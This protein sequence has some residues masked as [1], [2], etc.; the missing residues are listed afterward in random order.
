MRDEIP[1]MEYCTVKP[2]C[3]KGVTPPSNGSNCNPT[4]YSQLQFEE[5]PRIVAAKQESQVFVVYV[6]FDATRWTEIRCLYPSIHHVLSRNLTISR[7]VLEQLNTPALASTAY[8]N[9]ELGN[10]CIRIPFIMFRHSVRRFATTACKAAE[11]AAQMEARNAYGV[12]VSK[13]QGV[14]NGLT[15]CK[16]YSI[17]SSSL[18]A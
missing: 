15:E 5:F 7:E 16:L 17:S 9:W 8:L 4:R 3:R 11:T 13:A 18:G 2:L 10:T 14:V 12:S 1:P 6:C